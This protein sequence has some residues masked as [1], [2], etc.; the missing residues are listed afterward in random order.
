MPNPYL[1]LRFRSGIN[2]T[3]DKNCC[4]NYGS[5]SKLSLPTNRFSWLYSE[6]SEFTYQCWIKLAVEKKKNHDK[7]S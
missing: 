4:N 2:L 3:Y 5:I 7:I 6:L 1:N